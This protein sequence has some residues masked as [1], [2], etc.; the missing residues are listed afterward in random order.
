[1][2]FK[3]EIIINNNKD[4]TTYEIE[5]KNS[6]NN[7]INNNCSIIFRKTIKNEIPK[8]S[9]TNIK[10]SINGIIDINY[11]KISSN[12]YSTL[13]SFSEKENNS[14][15]SQ[16]SSFYSIN[17]I[18]MN[19]KDSYKNEYEGTMDYFKDIEKYFYNIMPE[20]FHIYKNTKN[21]LSKNIFHKLEN[22]KQFQDNKIEQNLN[23]NNIYVPQVS[24]ILYYSYNYFCHNYPSIK[25]FNNNSDEI[26]DEDKDKINKNIN[27]FITYN[28][29]SK[30][31][32]KI[33]KKQQKINNINYNKKNYKEKNEEINYDY[34][35]NY[36][37]NMNKQ[38]KK[39]KYKKTFNENNFNKNYVNKNNKNDYKK[40]SNNIKKRNNYY[41]NKFD[42]IKE[43]AIMY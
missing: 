28:K 24:N 33:N 7:T 5:E 14:Q 23:N 3:A 25:L 39:S 12:S 40:K 21:Y 20:K 1:M 10:A 38:S 8:E 32:I 30:N 26:K 13:S 37:Y 17:S 15:P 16:D 11:D 9:N 43:N 35:I 6:N 29:S 19:E 41:Y 36:D 27:Q 18:N 31:D 4:K 34:K 22:D 42:F 2:E